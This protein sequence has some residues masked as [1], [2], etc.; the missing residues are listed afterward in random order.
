MREHVRTAA[1][2]LGGAAAAVLAFALNH[3]AARWIAGAFVVCA[4][5]ACAYMW[6]EP[7][8]K[9]KMPIWAKGVLAVW[10][11]TAP[12]MFLFAAMSGMASESGDS[13]SV[14]FIVAAWTY[15]LSIV[16][17]FFLRRK[18][19]ALVFLP[20]LNVIA[21]F[22]TGSIIPHPLQA[23]PPTIDHMIVTAGRAYCRRPLL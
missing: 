1:K 20:C 23:V 11:L 8:D 21:W 16:T 3:S 4:L 14:C 19:P 13:R 6:F 22:W 10:I 5:S 18:L 9:P 2:I 12:V 15:P 17:A 7:D